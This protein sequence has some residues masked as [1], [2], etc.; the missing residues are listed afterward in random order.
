[1]PGRSPEALVTVILLE[2]AAMVAPSTAIVPVLRLVMIG[3]M[4]AP[5][6]V[7]RMPRERPVQSETLREELPLAA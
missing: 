7:T 3:S 5:V 4:T 2:P 1:M 6:P